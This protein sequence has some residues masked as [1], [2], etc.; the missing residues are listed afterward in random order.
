MGHRSPLFLRVAKS[1]VS[2]FI[3]PNRSR[4]AGIISGTSGGGSGS[5]VTPTGGLSVEDETERAFEVTR[6]GQE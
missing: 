4:T 6:P 2:P 1:L 3:C 5:G